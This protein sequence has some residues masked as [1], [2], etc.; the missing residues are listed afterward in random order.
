MTTLIKQIVAA[1]KENQVQIICGALAMNG[2][3]NV[4]RTYTSL[5]R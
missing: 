2:A 3:A 1:Y 4:Y 5:T